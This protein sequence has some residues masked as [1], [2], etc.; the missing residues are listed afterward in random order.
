MLVGYRII[1]ILINSDFMKFIY[2]FEL[3][4]SE[5]KVLENISS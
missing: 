2:L 3:I 5:R 1:N 4:V